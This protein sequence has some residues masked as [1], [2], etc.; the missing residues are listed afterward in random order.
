MRAFFAAVVA[1]SAGL[2]ANAAS[3]QNVTR[4]G[5]Y[6]YNADG[7]R[8]FIKGVAYQE[9]GSSLFAFALVLGRMHNL[10]HRGGHHGRQQPFQRALDI[11]R[12]SGKQHGLSTRHSLPQAAHRE[13]RP[14]LQ[15][16]LVSQP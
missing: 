10:F 16:Q 13:H 11:H 1:L 15:R 2:L 4:S 3:I 5:R 12:S 14:H 6:L 7:T 8:F 9:Q